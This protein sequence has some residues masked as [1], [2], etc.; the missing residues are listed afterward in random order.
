M[1][2]F[3]KVCK[4]RFRFSFREC[5]YS[6]EVLKRRFHKPR[7]KRIKILCDLNFGTNNNVIESKAREVG[8]EALV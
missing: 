1:C 3:L 7:I 8:L 4:K 2:A 5:S 6:L